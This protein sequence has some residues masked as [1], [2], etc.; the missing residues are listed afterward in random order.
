MTKIQWKLLNKLPK[1]Q[2][3]KLK[4]ILDRR[5]AI[6]ESLKSAQSGDTVIITGKGCESWI[7]WQKERRFRGTTEKLLKKKWKR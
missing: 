6:R 1:G 5:E 2:M 7:V 3:E 4:K